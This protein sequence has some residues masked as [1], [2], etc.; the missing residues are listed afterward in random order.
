ML[1][2]Y[3]CSVYFLTFKAQLSS[4]VATGAM[5]PRGTGL[6]TFNINFSLSFVLSDPVTY[7]EIYLSK[8]IR[9]YTEILKSVKFQHFQLKKK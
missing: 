7:C 8:G 6:C 1:N 2:N 5:Q 3:R 4:T 9:N